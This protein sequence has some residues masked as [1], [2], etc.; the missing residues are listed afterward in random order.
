MQ[1][2]LISDCELVN[3]EVNTADVSSIIEIL[4]DTLE[5][6]WPGGSGSP[7]RKWY[8]NV[9]TGKDAI[10]DK[11]LTEGAFENSRLIAWKTG[12]PFEPENLFFRTVDSGRLL[13]MHL[14]D[15]RVQFY[16]HK[17]LLEKIDK[18]PGGR[19]KWA[20]QTLGDYMHKILVL[21]NMHDKGGADIPIIVTAWDEERTNLAMNYWVDLSKGEW[22]D[23]EERKRYTE[24]DMFCRRILPC[25]FQTNN[26]VRA[27]LSDPEVGY[28]PPFIMFQSVVPD[29]K[30]CV[31]FTKPLH[32]PPPALVQNMPGVCNNPNCSHIDCAAVDMTASRSLVENSHMVRKWDTVSTKRI[33]CNLW[34]C[35]AEHSEDNAVKLQ[36]CQRCREVLYCSTA[37]QRLDWNVHKNV[38]E[39]RT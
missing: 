23:E 14:A 2:A 7:Y 39:K 13:P 19:K 16:A 3:Y 33:L 28:V 34:G 15:F 25:F 26:L 36:R 9:A 20:A 24:C 11:E 38:C 4:F 22:S 10:M 30:T 31:L 21:R 6:G 29:G 32:F 12:K 37:H 18:V 17:N 5:E 1:P 8:R 35:E 27:L